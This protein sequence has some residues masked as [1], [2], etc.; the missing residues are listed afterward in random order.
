LT[1]QAK[2][3]AAVVP[4]I[5][6]PLLTLGWV[7]Y[8]ELRETSSQKTLREMA[9]LVDQL[10]QSMQEV[11][12]TAQANVKLFSNSNLL[13]KYVLTADEWE[14]YSLLQPTL[15]RLF[16]SYQRAYPSYYEIRVLR[17][18]GTE[19]A[20]ASTRPRTGSADGGTA[21]P[22]WPALDHSP[23]DLY[24]TFVR[25]P[26]DGHVSLVIAKRLKLRDPSVDPILAKPI[27]RGY[28]VIHVDLSFVEQQVR[29]HR[30]AES[31]WMFL[32]DDTG[33]LMFQPPHSHLRARLPPQLFDALRTAVA[34]GEAVR[35]SYEGRPTFFQGTRLHPNL[36]LFADL[37]ERELFAASRQLGKAV[38]AITAVTILVTVVL[39]VAFL[40]RLMVA[41]IQRLGRA[42]VEI[43]RGNLSVPIDP[44]GSDE[45]AGLA[46]SLQD[47]AN[48]LQR[49]SDQIR[50]LAFHDSLTGLPN[51]LMFRE[52][53][54]HAIEHAK[55]AGRALA[56]LFLDVDNF[57]RVNDTLGHRF[58][59]ELLKEL[60]RHL[61]DCLRRGDAVARVEPD[62][63]TDMVA[64][65]GGDEF[66][67]LLKDLSAPHAAGEVARRILALLSQ[68]LAV[69]EHTLHVT[70]S[71][72]ITLYPTDGEDVDALI[73]N[74]DV[75]MY[76][77]K[78]QGKNSYQYYSHS[79]NT[80][81]VHR[82]AMEDRLRK[83]VEEQH[84]FLQYQPQ[85]DLHTD[86]IAG[87]EALLRW[88][89]PEL[90]TV[91]PEDFLPLAEET[92]LVSSLTEWLLREACRHGKQW[93]DAGLGPH[94]V[95]V[96][97]SGVYI[98]RSDLAAL[99][100]EVLTETG[101]DPTRLEIEIRET[102][103]IAMQD[104]TV[105][106][107]QSIKGLGARICLGDFGA[108]PSSLTWLRRFPIDRLKLGSTLVT[109]L[110]DDQEDAAMVRTIVAM[111]RGL[112]LTVAA[113]G[114]ETPPQLDFVRRAGCDLAQ[115][116]LFGPAVSPD[117]VPSLLR[118]ESMPAGYQQAGKH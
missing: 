12:S 86:R 13:Q 72:G 70:A 80:A 21:P 100:L 27:L 35:M 48:S 40:K 1:L 99:V 30:I 97:I 47:M 76:E 74:A 116:S 55:R 53:V 56:L 79:M 6:I 52:Y 11:M 58:G 73:R 114:V 94:Y 67:I 62:G 96:N 3:L 39:I 69:G 107:L 20:I 22:Y 112:G 33:R 19:D 50:F 16:A 4:L 5:V 23:A 41:P 9:V 108:G 46:A 109:S 87:L 118:G 18:D 64:R 49:S 61:T 10:S 105:R 2:I 59:D 98:N 68:P 111:A 43:G 28:L 95:S 45:I 101:L 82:L 25:E 92:G 42:A 115:G 113:P 34:R 51:R 26:S 117:Q 106:M 65:L 71:I 8:E 110:P 37:P 29:Q 84:M 91:V 81:A 75:A 57:K 14:R 36:Y 88:N 24:T 103:A 15:L 60:A 78:A 44:S 32:T 89:D 54:S 102:S 90:G 83:A 63:P 66:L 85:V 17:T 104:R 77:A 7:G 38:A 31:G 93:L